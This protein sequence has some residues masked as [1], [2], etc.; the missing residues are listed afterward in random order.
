MKTMILQRTTFASCL[1][2]AAWTFPLQAQQN[3]PPSQF[4]VKLNPVLI[5]SWPALQ[6]QPASA[7]TVAG[8]YAFVATGCGLQVVDVSDPANP[9]SV[10]GTRW[11]S[12]FGCYSVGIAVSGNYAF[13]AADSDGL[14][15]IDVSD[16]RRPQRIA[17]WK[18]NVGAQTWAVALSGNRAYLAV[19]SG[20]HV[21]DVSDPTRPQR[22]AQYEPGAG[23]DIAVSGNY[24]YVAGG[25]LVVI[26]ISDP[27]NPRSVGTASGYY[28]RVAVSGS[29]AYMAG[30]EECPGGWCRGTGLQI[31]DVSDSTNPRKV[32]MQSGGFDP[33]GV[34]TA[35]NYVYLLAVGG[36]EGLLQ[37]IDVAD[38][39]NPRQLGST[40]LPTPH[41]V[42]VS[43]NKIF[44]AA[45]DA[46]LAIYEM[47]AFI[48]SI[49]KEG[50]NIK[51][52]WEGFGP[53]RLQRATRLA[54]PDW[55]DL[56]GFE[57]TN[58]ATLPGSNGAEFFRLVRP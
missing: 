38:P 5:G 29:Y 2:I 51:L 6:T 56:P 32:G 47:P 33:G 34:A 18:E 21:L 14:V 22:L 16:P 40:A 44:V 54:D 52:A 36:T 4:N 27:A 28:H 37:V 8:N 20:L 17:H 48:K 49:A 19:S 30:H 25:G 58:T 45:G 9:R 42:A 53:A 3:P 13:V 24:A 15:V 39:A 55:S 50:P 43:Q 1:F 23:E 10:G 7:V 57:G 26:D 31:I 35:G 41:D 11:T 46:G 12:D